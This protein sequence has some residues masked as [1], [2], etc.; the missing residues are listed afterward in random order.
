MIKFLLVWFITVCLPFTF[1]IDFF[2]SGD[3]SVFQ[4]EQE[5]TE[6]ILMSA[7]LLS[8]TDTLQNLEPSFGSES[9]V[10]SW[11]PQPI[12][13]STSLYLFYSTKI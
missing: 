9:E 12:L 11:T 4:V 7:G 8:P 6:R 1:R 3:K 13:Q 5:Q 10:N 2:K